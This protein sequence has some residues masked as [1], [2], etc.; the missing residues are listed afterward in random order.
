M[1]TTKQ[2]D[3]PKKEITRKYKKKIKT[4]PNSIPDIKSPFRTAVNSLI[5]I[6]I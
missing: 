6:K 4:A 1:R 5:M 3:R 2:V